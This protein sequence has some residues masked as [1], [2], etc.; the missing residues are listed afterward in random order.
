[1]HIHLVVHMHYSIAGSGCAELSVFWTVYN[2]SPLSKGKLLRSLR[3]LVYVVGDQ[4]RVFRGTT[5]RNNNWIADG[6]AET[7]IA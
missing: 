6:T 3:D 4:E 2:S 5:F 7:H 1:M